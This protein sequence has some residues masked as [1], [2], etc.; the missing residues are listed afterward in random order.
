M[1]YLDFAIVSLVP[2]SLD[3]YP[4]VLSGYIDL[5]PLDI[6]F[7]P[8]PNLTGCLL[9]YLST[10]NDRAKQVAEYVKHAHNGHNSQRN[11]NP[12]SR[13]T[14]QHYRY[15]YD[16]TYSPSITALPLF[17][18]VVVQP[19]TFYAHH[20]SLSYARSLFIGRQTHRAEM[21]VMIDYVISGIHSIHVLLSCACPLVYYLRTIYVLQSYHREGPR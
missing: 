18:F 15:D 13:H 6:T 21:N 7:L 8:S 5:L 17:G 9:Y 12:N 2:L 20:K 16:L 10:A 14:H 1:W 11:T 3:L 4:S 19:G